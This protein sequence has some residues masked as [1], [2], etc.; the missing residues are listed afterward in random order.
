M[1][2]VVGQSYGE[3][4]VDG[5]MAVEESTTL[6]EKRSLLRDRKAMH[7]LGRHEQ[8]QGVMVMRVVC[9]GRLHTSR[10]DDY[11]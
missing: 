3:V 7:V 8:R 10:L 4:G 11:L 2:M 9:L 1:M 5:C 6:R